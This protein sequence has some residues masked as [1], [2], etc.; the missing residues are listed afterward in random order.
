VTEHRITRAMPTHRCWDITV[1]PVVMAQ[2]GDT[3][4]AETDDFAAGQITRDSPAAALLEVDFDLIYPLAGPIHVAGAEPGD[5]LAIELL[6]FELP[7]WGWACIIPGFGLLPPGEFDEPV[8]RVFDLTGGDT[9]ELCPGVGIPIEPFCGTMGVPG[10]GMLDVPIPP[11]HAGGG[12][13]DCRHLTVGTTLYLPVGAEGGLL[14]LG[15]AHAAQG[16]G[17]VA[18]SGI[19]CAMTTRI[20][21]DVVKGLDIPAPQ[22]RR[23]P[24]SLTPRVDHAGWYATTG[25]ETDLMEASRSAVRAMIDHLVR[26]RGLSREDAYILCALAGD[27]KITEVVDAPMWMVGCFMPDAVFSS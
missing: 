10:A 16:D 14:S 6:G 15:D 3:I 26:E 9:T 7:E 19:E 11:P 23:P 1:P 17:E 18:I 13:V 5:A 27:L 2:P 12:N 22:L 8:L 20:R 25:V 4:V 21:V 24:G